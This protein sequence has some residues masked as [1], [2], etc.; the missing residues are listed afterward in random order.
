ML[1]AM[2]DDDRVRQLERMS[3]FITLVPFN[4]ALGIE[5]VTMGDG[6]ARFQLPY[7]A[8]LVGN[9][10]SGILHGGAI[11]ALLDAACGAAVF[12]ALKTPVPIATLDLR[13][14]YLGPAAVGRVVL[15]E[16]HCYRV[17]KHIAFV[18]GSAFHDD[19]GEPIASAAGTFMLSTTLMR[20]PS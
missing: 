13:I 5:V 2:S 4:H 10:A 7:R 11:T 18:R 15:A 1:A 8:D 16:A 17:T 12:M 19:G 9:P 14:D 6:R 20:R 3:K